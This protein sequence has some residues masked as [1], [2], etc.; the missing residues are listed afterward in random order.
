MN[1]DETVG[2]S[3]RLPLRDAY[4]F[5]SEKGASDTGSE[6]K[7]SERPPGIGSDLKRAKILNVL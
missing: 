6:I 4:P 7:T 1:K 2:E 5:L 3:G